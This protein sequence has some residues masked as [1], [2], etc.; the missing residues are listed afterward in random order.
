MYTLVDPI[1][2]TDSGG[3]YIKKLQFIQ[4]T[5]NFYTSVHSKSNCPLSWLSFIRA[6][7]LFVN[8]CTERQ[9]HYHIPPTLTYSKIFLEILW[10]MNVKSHC[11][12][13]SASFAPVWLDTYGI[14]IHSEKTRRHV[15]RSGFPTPAP[16]HVPEKNVMFLIIVVSCI[17]IWDPFLGNFYIINRF[18][19][20][21]Q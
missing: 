3:K 10:A 19:K 15:V 4:N 8:F 21:K 16:C 20:G 17:F 7:T 6:P 12:F 18:F 1:V 2:N 11:L 13:F 5:E 9:G 14:M